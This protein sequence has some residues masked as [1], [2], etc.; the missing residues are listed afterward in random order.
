MTD[1][2]VVLTDEARE[3]IRALDGAARRIV[4]KALAKLQTD[5][6]L[7]GAPLG[8]KKT[9]DLT[10]FRKLVVGDRTYRIVY[11]VEADGTVAVVFVV[12]GR[13][14]DEVYRLALARIQLYTD[15]AGAAILRQI[16]GTAWS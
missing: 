12:A 4:V 9:G 15:P 16:I 10:G 1:A 2:K 3:D 5:P 8:S 13:A 11:R 14:D 6:E 7:R